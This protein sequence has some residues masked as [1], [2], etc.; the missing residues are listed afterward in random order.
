MVYDE[1][2]EFLEHY[3][4]KGMRWGVVNEDDSSGSQS[5]V[6]KLLRK[7]PSPDLT[8]EQRANVAKTQKAHDAKFEA[9]EASGGKGWRP[10][11]KQVAVVAAGALFTAAVIYKVKTGNSPSISQGLKTDDYLSVIRSADTPDWVHGLAGTKMSPNDYFGLMQNS[12]NRV[13]SGNGL[14]TRESFSQKEFSLPVGHEFFRISHAAETSFNPATY[15]TSSEAD[16]SRYLAA[17]TSAGDSSK[18][19]K[20]KATSEVRVPDMTTKLN[21][22]REA[23]A[24]NGETNLSPARVIKQYN[25]RV[26]GDWETSDP[27]I[28]SFMDS[29]RKKGYHAIIDDMDAGVFGEAPLVLIDPTRVSA[30][31]VTPLSSINRSYYESILTDIEN[32]R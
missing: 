4:V 20:F 30:K 14:V 17:F 10:T 32:R 7:N 27:Y 6:Q 21:S 13:W 1:D 31:T 2:R 29:L 9:S 22:M 23:M 3:G 12:S 16:F 19:I 15:C 25:N 11:K 26:G 8:P 5:P 18:L 28:K 24:L